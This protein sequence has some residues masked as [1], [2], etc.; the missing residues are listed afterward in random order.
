MQK[1]T[2]HILTSFLIF[3]PISGPQHPKR[4]Y[5]K[6]KFKLNYTTNISLLIFL[7]T[8]KLSLR[9]CFAWK[10]SYMILEIKL[11][12]STIYDSKNSIYELL[13]STEYNDK[14][15]LASFNFHFSFLFLSFPISH[16]PSSKQSLK[17]AI[18]HILS[19][20]PFPQQPYRIKIK[21]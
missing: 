15:C 21:W 11:T 10:F 1:L 14:I 20:S 6:L 9:K 8:K 3:L 18:F 16:F 5:R 19:I 7:D 17:D 2:W 12:S 13:P 4:F